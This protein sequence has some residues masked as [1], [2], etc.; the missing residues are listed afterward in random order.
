MYRERYGKLRGTKCIAG[1]LLGPDSVIFCYIV[2]FRIAP[3]TPPKYATDTVS[4]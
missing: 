1:V 4:S 2:N 3:L